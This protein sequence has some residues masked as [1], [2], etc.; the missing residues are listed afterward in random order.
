MT[1]EHIHDQVSTWIDDTLPKYIL[2][3][4]IF[5]GKQELR[6]DIDRVIDIINSRNCGVCVDFGEFHTSP[7][8]PHTETGCMRFSQT[9]DDNFACNLWQPIN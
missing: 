2:T 7:D 9:F 3:D 6:R 4:S 8:L 1:T 5:Y